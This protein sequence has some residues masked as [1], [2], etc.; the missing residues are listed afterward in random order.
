[1]PWLTGWRPELRSQVKKRE[2][3]E[4][5]RTKKQNLKET[6]SSSQKLLGR[7]TNQRIPQKRETRCQRKKRKKSRWT[8]NLYEVTYELSLI[9]DL[10]QNSQGTKGHYFFPH[11]F[12][13]LRRFT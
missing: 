4:S 7:L 11:L 8:R 9:P 3:A 1:M 6:K 13:Q 2:Q 5:P 12:I 10:F